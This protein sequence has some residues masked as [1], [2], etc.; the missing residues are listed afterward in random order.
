MRRHINGDLSICIIALKKSDEVG[1]IRGSQRSVRDLPPQERNDAWKVGEPIRNMKNGKSSSVEQNTPSLFSQEEVSRY[2]SKIREIAEKTKD[3][4]PEEEDKFFQK[5]FDSQASELMKLLKERDKRGDLEG[6]EPLGKESLLY[7]GA[8]NPQDPQEKEQVGSDSPDALAARKLRKML[9]ADKLESEKDVNNV[10]GAILVDTSLS[11]TKEFAKMP[12]QMVSGLL[13]EFQKNARKN[14][15]SG[16]GWAVGIAI[17]G[18]VEKAISLPFNQTIKKAQEA[19][20]KFGEKYKEEAPKFLKILQQEGNN[21]NKIKGSPRSQVSINES[22]RQ[23]RF[24][25]LLAFDPDRQGDVGAGPTIGESGPFYGSDRYPPPIPR[26][27]G[28]R[29]DY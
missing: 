29:D 19:E 27:G 24:R 9:P 17:V 8:S 6:V 14:S 16:M 21:T 3:M 28:G 20:W 7:G 22:N 11:I 5:E 12:T 13:K 10:M 18:L 4:S 25:D 15:E 26:G 23:K 2:Q 1:S